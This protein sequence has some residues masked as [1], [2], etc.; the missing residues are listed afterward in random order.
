MLDCTVTPALQV[1]LIK[2]DTLLFIRNSRSRSR[3]ENNR[4]RF[5]TFWGRTRK[6]RKKVGMK[7]TVIEIVR[8]LNL[9]DTLEVVFDVASGVRRGVCALTCN[10]NMKKHR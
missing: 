3:E 10:A 8:G 7:R 2:C 5:S 1:K 4:M 9:D 6:N